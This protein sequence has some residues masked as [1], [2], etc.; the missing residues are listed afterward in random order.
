MLDEPKQPNRSQS[1]GNRLRSLFSDDEDDD[2]EQPQPTWQDN[3]IVPTLASMS[4]TSTGFIDPLLTSSAYH[5]HQAESALSQL[6]QIVSDPADWKKTLKH[7]SGVVVYMCSHEKMP[8][9]KG[10]A[11]IHGFSPQSVFYVVGMRKLWDELYDDGN[12]VENLNETTSLT[13]EVSKPALRQVD[14]CRP[15][16]VL[17]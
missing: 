9:F 16:F 7:K 4:H 8:I 6:K 15:L 10:E 3:P 13:Y 12:L 5:I 1:F 17:C 2:E 11:I 14:L